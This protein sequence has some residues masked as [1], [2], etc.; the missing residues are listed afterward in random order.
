MVRATAR[1]VPGTHTGGFGRRHFY[2]DGRV[3]GYNSCLP[4]DLTVYDQLVPPQV[5]QPT[6][7]AGMDR[8]I[9]TFRSFLPDFSLSMALYD[10]LH[11][12]P[13]PTF[14]ASRLGLSCIAFYPTRRCLGIW[15]WDRPGSSLCCH[16]CARGGG[17]QNQ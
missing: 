2:L 3:G 16:V 1:S 12:L 7:A 5:P 13:S 4:P 15:F 14:T 8:I 11:K 6:D 10:H 9:V 17:D